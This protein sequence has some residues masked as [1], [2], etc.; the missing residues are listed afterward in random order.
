MAPLPGSNPTPGQKAAATRKA[1]KNSRLARAAK[2][3]ETKARK[4]QPYQPPTHLATEQVDIK[5]VDPDELY[6]LLKQSRVNNYRI[7]IECER[8]ESNDIVDY[9]VPGK[10]FVPTA[11][12]SWK[13][14]PA[15]G[16]TKLTS[17]SAK[18]ESTWPEANTQLT[19]FD[20][21]RVVQASIKTAT[22]SNRWPAT[23][24]TNG[25]VRVSRQSLGPPAVME[26]DGK[27]YLLLYKQR[28][29]LCGENGRF[30][31]RVSFDDYKTTKAADGSAMDLTAGDEYTETVLVLPTATEFIEQHLS[32]IVNELVAEDYA[33]L[34]AVTNGE[35][36][37]GNTEETVADRAARGS[38]LIDKV[39]TTLPTGPVSEL[40][41]PIG[42][43][44]A[45]PRKARGTST[46]RTSPAPRPRRP[47]HSGHSSLIPDD[48]S[49]T[50]ISPPRAR[51]R[52]TRRMQS[53]MEFKPHH[54]FTARTAALAAGPPTKHAKASDE[55]SVAG[56]ESS[57]GRKPIKERYGL[58]PSSALPPTEEKVTAKTNSINVLR[59]IG[60]L[61]GRIYDHAEEM[62]A[63]LGAIA[64]EAKEALELPSTEGEAKDAV[65]NQIAK[66]ATTSSGQL[67]DILK[68]DER[69]IRAQIDNLDKEAYQAYGE[70]SNS[71]YKARPFEFYDELDILDDWTARLTKKDQEM[72]AEEADDDKT[73]EDEFDF[74]PPTKKSRAY[75]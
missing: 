19:D 58:T 60:A 28:Y 55:L 10:S 13:D 11:G 53:T 50:E 22:R 65:L 67:L 57:T 61:F 74:E 63:R 25:D 69:S 40:A 73:S 46:P 30:P 20:I 12:T 59:T 45:R 16:W 75:R 1:K 41:N 5:K 8:P 3:Q 15:L 70:A 49:E 6:E 32:A 27:N 29:L 14:H 51:G 68:T 39:K 62:D 48:L 42:L 23:F 56:T 71:S 44:Q 7:K 31:P 35:K 37:H 17:P 9:L 26:S 2:G 64:R 66:F 18:D 33:K 4:A 24:D 43:A 21:A 36:D 72:E 52:S 38:R 34:L 54:P 47:Y